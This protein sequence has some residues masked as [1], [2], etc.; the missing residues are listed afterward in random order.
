[1]PSKEP[2]SRPAV[3]IPYELREAVDFLS[4]NPE[5]IWKVHLLV[6]WT[7]L[8]ICPA[9]TSQCEKNRD[10]GVGRRGGGKFFGGNGKAA[11]GTVVRKLGC[12][13]KHRVADT[14]LACLTNSLLWTKK[15]S[16]S[17]HQ[18]MMRKLQYYSA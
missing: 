14:P 9:N 16:F 8:E 2:S 10:G 7:V 1:M 18:L 4:A 17:C 13:E 5:V 15:L 3:L 6:I 12:K 11:K